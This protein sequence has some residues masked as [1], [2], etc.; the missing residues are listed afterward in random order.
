MYRSPVQWHCVSLAS[1]QD[2]ALLRAQPTCT[3]LVLTAK[4]LAQFCHSQHPHTRHVSYES[5]PAQL[6]NTVPSTI[7]HTHTTGQKTK[8]CNSCTFDCHTKPLF[9]FSQ[10]YEAV[11]VAICRTNY[12]RDAHNLIVT[13][14]SLSLDGTMQV[15]SFNIIRQWTHQGRLQSAQDCTSVGHRV[16]LAGCM[17]INNLMLSMAGASFH[18]ASQMLSSHMC[19]NSFLSAAGRGTLVEPTK[20]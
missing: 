15:P 7:S 19:S 18:A 16:C 3:V 13:P 2:V 8:P 5:I 20:Q 1:W 10:E 14:Q 6:L 9:I 17:A 12:C 11:V 4:L